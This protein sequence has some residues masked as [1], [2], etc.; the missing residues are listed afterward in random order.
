MQ[1]S[2]EKKVA[3]K[4]ANEPKG[5]FA[6]I[7]VVAVFWR[8]ARV[9]GNK[10]LSRLSPVRN[11]EKCCLGVVQKLCGQDEAG[12]WSKNIYSCPTLD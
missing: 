6:Q 1:Y 10:I 7:S 2:S 4:P 3:P 12:W 8:G 9:A 5:P 11:Q